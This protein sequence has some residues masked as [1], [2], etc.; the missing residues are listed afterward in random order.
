MLPN[1]GES[2]AL[3]EPYTITWLS[4][5]DILDVTIDF[6]IDNGLTIRQSAICLRTA[7]PSI[8]SMQCRKLLI[9]F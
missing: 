3:G 4:P 2:L 1:G 7:H 5:P 6:S 8:R 9:M